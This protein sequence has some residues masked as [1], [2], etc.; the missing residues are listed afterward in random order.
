MEPLK[1]KVVW[2]NEKKGYGFIQVEEQEVFLHH[3]SLDEF[4][5]DAVYP[6]D[7]L[8]VDVSEN[9]RGAVISAVH[10]IER[11]RVAQVFH[12][13]DIEENE[14]KGVVKFFNSAKGYGFI[15]I[16][17][18]ERDVFVHLR[19]L[20]DCGIHNL[21]EGQRLLLHVT[22]EGKGPQAVGVRM[23]EKNGYY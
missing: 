20:R 18:D 15:E 23:L 1:G 6:G 12:E 3:S 7:I 11:E 10:G 22:D 13:E 19:T 17:G 16:G 8:N 14:V 9:E 21:K 4:G 2:Y 5:I